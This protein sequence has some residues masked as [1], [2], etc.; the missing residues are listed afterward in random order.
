MFLA[1]LGSSGCLLPPFWWWFQNY[2]SH[3]HCNVFNLLSVYRK[4]AIPVEWNILREWLCWFL[5]FPSIPLLRRKC[6]S[7]AKFQR[8]SSCLRISY[9]SSSDLLL[10][11]IPF[12]LLSPFPWQKRPNI[13]QRFTVAIGFT[14]SC[15][16]FLPWPVFISSLGSLFMPDRSVELT[17][18]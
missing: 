1:S 5:Y 3:P 15:M 11:K 18:I 16:F 4:K 2:L 8:R 12:A 9:Q 13:S 7:L 6:Q 10:C 17:L 14:S